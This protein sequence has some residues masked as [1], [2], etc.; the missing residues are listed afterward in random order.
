MDNKEKI[1]KN[2][3][4]LIESL[5]DENLTL[6]NQKNIVDSMEISYFDVFYSNSKQV[7]TLRIGKSS[8]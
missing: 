3:K 7:L 2:L 6:E 8:I 4:A 5:A 1:R